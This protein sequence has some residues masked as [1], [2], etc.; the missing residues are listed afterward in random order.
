MVISFLQRHPKIIA[1]HIRPEENLGAMLIEILELYGTRFNFDRVGIAI[2]EGGSYFDA[3]QY[4][5]MNQNVWKRICIQDPNDPGN[6][7]AKASF[8]SDGIIQVFADAFRAL[9][10]RCYL[11]HARIRKGE[12]YPWGTVSGSIL[13]SIIERPQAWARSRINQM[14]KEQV[15]D[16][17]HL[18]E[19]ITSSIMEPPRVE[20]TTSTS[21]KDGKNKLNRRERRA[22]QREMQKETRR[23]SVES[24][25]I[26]ESALHSGHEKTLGSGTS[27]EWPIILDD[28]S[29]RRP[30]SDV[31]EL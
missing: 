10:T 23:R 31:I 12:K 30:P 19:P 26:Q 4:H 9:T 8:N 6:N 7:I 29:P 20:R 1:G 11:V 25:P 24:S 28:S 14:W 18:D 22:V 5:C 21:F 27:K 2:E 15:R 17:I 3:Y 13:D 16:I